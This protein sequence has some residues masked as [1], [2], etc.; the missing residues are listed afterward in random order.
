MK[1]FSFHNG[2]VTEGI[3]AGSKG[4]VL[5]ESTKKLTKLPLDSK[6]PPTIINGLIMDAEASCEYGTFKKTVIK[7]SEGDSKAVILRILTSSDISEAKVSGNWSTTGKWEIVSTGSGTTYVDSVI[8]LYN[9]QTARIESESGEK[10]LLMNNR[11]FLDL[12]SI[13]KTIKFL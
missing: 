9:G 5:G 6:N 4:V 11:G 3:A 2:D 7:K 8:I 13:V 10:W 1:C 12:G